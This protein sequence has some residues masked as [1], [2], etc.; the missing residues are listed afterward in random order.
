M[1]KILTSGFWCSSSPQWKLDI[2]ILWSYQRTE[3]AM[4]HEKVMIIP[5][6]VVKFGKKNGGSGD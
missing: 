6:E 4:K 1:K 5:I 2:Q 3:K